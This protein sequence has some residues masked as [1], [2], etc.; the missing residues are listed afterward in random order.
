[1]NYILFCLNNLLNYILNLQVFSTL[2]QFIQGCDLAKDR[3][4]V[5]IGEAQIL[6]FLLPLLEYASQQSNQQHS[7]PQTNHCQLLFTTFMIELCVRKT[8]FAMHSNPFHAVTGKLPHQ[9]GM[10]SRNLSTTILK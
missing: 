10:I 3:L 6:A 2:C 7:S 4:H 1:M 5:Y 8:N 9:L